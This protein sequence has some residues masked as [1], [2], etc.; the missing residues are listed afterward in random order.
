MSLDHLGNDEYRL[1][2]EFTLLKCPNLRHI[3]EKELVHPNEI[4]GYKDKWNKYKKYKSVKFSVKT[5][6]GLADKLISSNRK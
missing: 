4:N 5:W 2:C 6:T 1:G 3:I